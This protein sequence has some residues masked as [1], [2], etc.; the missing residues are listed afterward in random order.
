MATSRTKTA[1]KRRRMKPAERETLRQA[2]DILR[3]REIEGLD[4][5]RS[6]RFVSCPVQDLIS[7]VASDVWAITHAMDDENKSALDART[8]T[9]LMRIAEHSLRLLVTR[10][11]GTFDF[12]TVSKAMELIAEMV[13]RQNMEIRGP[14]LR[15][16]YWSM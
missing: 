3:N 5:M 9:D 10:L 15:G 2:E 16:W 14:N 11:P 4:R 7:Q 12:K 6:S 1:S 8:A 13:A